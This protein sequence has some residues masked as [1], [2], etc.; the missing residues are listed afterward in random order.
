MKIL[1]IVS[2]LTLAG[3][4]APA[5]CLATSVGTSTVEQ[6]VNLG[7]RSNPAKIPLGRVPVISNYNYGIHQIIGEARACPEGAMRWEGGS[8]LDQNLASVFGIS[9]EPE[10]STQV[11]GK[12]VTL[13]IKPWKPPVYSPYTKEQVLAATVWCLVRSAGGTPETPLE[14]LVVAEGAEDKAL[15]VKYSGQYVTRR[16]K[17]G[18]EV[19][20]AKVPGTVLEEDAKGIAWVTFPDVPRKEAFSPVSP[21]MIIVKSVGDGDP[22]WHLVPVWGS[23][24]GDEDFLKLVG[25]SVNMCHLVY[26][27]RGLAEANAFVAESG[28]DPVR[29]SLRTNSDESSVAFLYPRV[30]PETFAAELFALVLATQPTD[31]KPLRVSI[32][33]LESEV[34]A[35]ENFRNA[36]G[37]KETPSEKTDEGIVLECEFVWNA[38]EEKLSKG[39]VPLVQM[40]S[41]GWI[42]QKPESENDQETPAPTLPEPPQQPAAPS[43]PNAETK[44]QAEAKPEATPEPQPEAVPEAE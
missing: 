31:E 9:V 30:K 10:D 21:V 35:Y 22:G 44:P 16:G 12:P 6:P 34:P 3:W 26:P 25:S 7:T 11:P 33:L 36:P 20:P 28:V 43:Q 41:L 5:T 42:D 2:V 8:E 14:V 18:E 15:E 27:L 1:R 17:D 29:H 39:S 23:G 32:E 37:W 40:K 13:R 24:R 19:P 38:A 4:T